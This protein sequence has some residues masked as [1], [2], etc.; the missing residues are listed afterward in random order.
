MRSTAGP[1]ERSKAAQDVLTKRPQMAR[2]GFGTLHDRAPRERPLRIPAALKCTTMRH[3]FKPRPRP[4]PSFPLFAFRSFW[5]QPVQY[6]LIH[7]TSSTSSAAAFLHNPHHLATRAIQHLVR[8]AADASPEDGVHAHPHHVFGM[9]GDDVA[10]LQP[11][12]VLAL[13]LQ[14]PERVVIQQLDQLLCRLSPATLEICRPKES[15]HRGSARCARSRF[16]WQEP[17]RLMMHTRP[18]ALF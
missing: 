17:D 13:A 18:L 2:K 8:K 4:L 14:R 7:P 6:W 1:P 16:V 9:F 12:R 10:E 15:C 5:E 11:Q 3:S